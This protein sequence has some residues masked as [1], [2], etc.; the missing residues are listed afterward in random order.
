MLGTSQ[1]ARQS[2]RLLALN[3]YEL[4]INTFQNNVF[5]FKFLR[6]SC[7]F[8]LQRNWNT[9]WMKKAFSFFCYFHFLFFFSLRLETE[10]FNEYCEITSTGTDMWDWGLQALWNRLLGAAYLVQ[11][12]TVGSI[13][14]ITYSSRS[15]FCSLKKAWKTSLVHMG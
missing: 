9:S 13:G 15:S 11:A 14:W 6:G 4:K 1:P 3:I 12:P 5:F 7:F 10:S 8:H 2:R